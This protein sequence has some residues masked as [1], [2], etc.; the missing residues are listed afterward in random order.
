MHATAPAVPSAVGVAPPAHA[1]V[2]G[3]SPM[4][5]LL[6]VLTA[7]GQV[8]GVEK[9]FGRISTVEQIQKG[10]AFVLA[11]PSH[12]L[13]G[14]RKIWR[15]CQRDRVPDRGSCFEANLVRFCSIS[16]LLHPPFGGL[17]VVLNFPLR[18]GCRD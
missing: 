14:S 7:A 11:S 10:S 17:C 5:H 3:R 2:R 1:A 6:H 8:S 18:H 16:P 13:P 4:L 9:A 15:G 12:L